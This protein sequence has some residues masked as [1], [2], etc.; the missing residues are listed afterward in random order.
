MSNGLQ[1]VSIRIEA[2]EHSAIGAEIHYYTEQTPQRIAEAVV[3]AT[4][5]AADDNR[6]VIDAEFKRNIASL[7]KL[8][9]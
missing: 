2:I 3:S 7:L 1:V 9:V 5:S 6:E 4:E 8:I